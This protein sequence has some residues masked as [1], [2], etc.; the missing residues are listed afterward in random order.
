MNFAKDRGI[1]LELNNNGHYIAKALPLFDC[2]WISNFAHE[3]E[4]VFCGGWMTIRLEGIRVVKTEQN[5]RMVIHALFVLDCILSGAIM[6]DDQD[7]TL[8][9]LNKLEIR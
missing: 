5:Y 9:K 2:S 3:D 1:I 8:L 6:G 7:K 4:R